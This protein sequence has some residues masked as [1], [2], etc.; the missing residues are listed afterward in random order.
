MFLKKILKTAK[1]Y[2]LRDLLLPVAKY[3]FETLLPPTLVNNNNKI[4]KLQKRGIFP[5]QNGITMRNIASM[6]P[7]SNLITHF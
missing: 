6:Q 3:I 7:K 4:N 2:I 5:S 1:F